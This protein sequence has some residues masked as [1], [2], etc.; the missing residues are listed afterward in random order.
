MKVAYTR[1]Q[2]VEYLG[3][4][5]SVSPLHPVVITKFI[6]GAREIECDAVASKGKLINWAISEHVENAGVHS[7]DA[8]MVLPSD[9]ISAKLHSRLVQVSAKI[10]QALEISGPMNVQYIV[11][12][13]DVKVIE[14][15]LRASRSFPFVSKTY[16]IDFIETATRIFLGQNLTPNPL[17]DMPLKHVCVKFPMFSFQRLL[18]ADPQLG[19]EM[20]STGEVACFGDNK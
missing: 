14:C 6:E 7:G 11:K 2:L 12:D 16:N 1:E 5:A 18:G 20:A 3:A 15:N 13:N 9:T 10:A 4:A 8:T 19:V 17:C